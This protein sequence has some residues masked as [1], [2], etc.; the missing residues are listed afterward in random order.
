MSHRG[1]RRTA[2]LV[3]AAIAWSLVASVVLGHGGEPEVEIDPESVVAGGRVEVAGENLADVKSVELVLVGA[4][5]RT[6]LGTP[7][8]DPE[9]HFTTNVTIPPETAAGPYVIEAD[10]QDG[11]LASAALVVEAAEGASAA[12]TASAGSGPTGEPPAAP[13]SAASPSPASSEATGEP[14]ASPVAA[15][16]TEPAASSDGTTIL[17]VIALAIVAGAVGGIVLA[18]R[19][20]ASA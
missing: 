20:R 19:G 5:S 13:S 9:G 16:E 2:S 18:R 8:V 12:A 15:P 1:A 10:G 7:E 14:A 11:P 3:V 17:A 6:T 4:G